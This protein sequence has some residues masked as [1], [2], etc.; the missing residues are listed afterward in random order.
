MAA[1]DL[2]A[3]LVPVG[4]SARGAALWEALSVGVDPAGAVLVA[5]ACRIADRLERLSA[6]V[7]GGEAEWAR[8]QL[9]R[10]GDDELVL[11]VDGALTEA[12]QQTQVLRQILGQ[13]GLV[14]SDVAPESGRSFLDLLNDRRADRESDSEAG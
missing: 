4:L 8:V 14:G 3:A 1:R 5:E 9:P 7:D 6:L 2:D 13:L 11:R 12:R 10:G